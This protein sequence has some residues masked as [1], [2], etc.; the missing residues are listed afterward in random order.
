[1]VTFEGLVEA[2][3]LDDALET[4]EREVEIIRSSALC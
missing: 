2:P 1:M 4:A 3:D